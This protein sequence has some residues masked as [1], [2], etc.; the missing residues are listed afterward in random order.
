MVENI[1]NAILVLIPNVQNLNLL[2]QFF[3]I[4]VCNVL[5]KTASKVMANR[6]KSILPEIISEEQSTFVPGRLISDNIIATYE[7]LHFF[8]R[9]KGKKH[10]SYAFK[11]DMMNA[12]DHVEWACLKTMMIKL[13]FAPTWIEVI[14]RIIP[15]V[16]LNI[17]NG[18]KL[19]E[20]KPSRGIR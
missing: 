8:K 9:N 11:L 16:S 20:F 2:S 6:L 10:R 15:S 12:Y 18:A 13:G 5:Y 17:M 7:C 19:E 4:R 3:P 1:N 14:M